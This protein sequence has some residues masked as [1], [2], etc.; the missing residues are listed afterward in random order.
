MSTQPRDRLIIAR[1]I[2]LSI[3]SRGPCV[4]RSCRVST[5]GQTVENQIRE[6]DIDGVAPQAI[7]E[8]VTGDEKETDIRLLSTVSKQ[9]GTIELK[10]GDR[11]TGTDLFNTINAI[12]LPEH[13]RSS[14]P[15][16]H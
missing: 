15:I 5:L 4:L 7:Q 1:Q 14:G 2:V 13:H 8:A 9:Q 3:F 16:S 10:L 12:G 6:I 11:R